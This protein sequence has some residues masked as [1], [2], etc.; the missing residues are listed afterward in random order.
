MIEDQDGLEQRRPRGDPARGLDLH[1]GVVLP[2]PQGA[3]P[4]AQLAEELGVD[5]LCIG[6]EL[7]QTVTKRQDDW[8]VLIGGMCRFRH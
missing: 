4:V 3:L 7:H 5:L 2:R 8:R 6:T 1:Q